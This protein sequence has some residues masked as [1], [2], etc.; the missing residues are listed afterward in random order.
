M[1]HVVWLAKA[2]KVPGAHG[3]W[4]VEPVEQDEPTGHAVHSEAA[5]KPAA[6]EYDPLGH[7]SAADE[8]SGQ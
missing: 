6:L 8:P 5:P 4:V 1:V 3:A 7:G 2:A